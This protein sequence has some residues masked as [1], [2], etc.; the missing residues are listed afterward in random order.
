MSWIGT[1]LCVLS[2]LA[3]AVPVGATAQSVVEGPLVLRLP[4]SARSV[5]VADAGLVS[6][7]ADVLF[8]NPGMLASARGLSLSMQRYASTATAGAMATITTVGS[9]TVG[10]GVQALRWKSS[11]TDYREAI[12]HGAPH[13]ATAWRGSGGINAS[14]SA[15][16]LGLAQTV[17]GV[18]LGAAVK[19]AEDAFGNATDGT[20]AVD[21]G[22]NRP[23]GPGT[24]AITVQNLGAGLRLAGESAGMPHRFGV[25]WGSAAIGRWEHWDLG[26]LAQLTVEGSDGFVRPA[27]G[28]ELGYV[29][30]DG[31]ALQLRG[32]L[33]APRE[34]DESPVTAGLGIT[35]DRFSLDYALEPMQGGSPA[36]HRVG[37]RFK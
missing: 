22:A 19:Y 20:V 1:V 6:S 32:G 35:V 28:V 5:S 31:V 17:K 12:Q 16:T 14:S 30:V 36:S 4:A 2:T 24:L 33:R 15:F 26:V 25:G 11:D 7:D 13:L 9:M 27:G 18:R 8:Y 10:L 23:L 34:Q 21:L 29:P 3:L 37:V